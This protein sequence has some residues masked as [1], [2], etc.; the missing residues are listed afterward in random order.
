MCVFRKRQLR[1]NNLVILLLASLQIP[2][3]VTLTPVLDS[4]LSLYVCINTY[5]SC[6]ELERRERPVTISM[7]IASSSDCLSLK[8][9]VFW[10]VIPYSVVDVY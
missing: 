6:H 5:G 7:K 1:C 3:D 2:L 8:S 9:I 4:C 10:K